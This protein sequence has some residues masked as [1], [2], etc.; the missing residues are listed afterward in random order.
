MPPGRSRRR[1]RCVGAHATLQYLKQAPSRPY[2]SGFAIIPHSHDPFKRRYEIGLGTTGAD[3]VK[4]A[5]RLSL[6]VVVSLLGFAFGWV[7]YWMGGLVTTRR[8]QFPDKENAGLT[9]GTFQLPFDEIA[10][11]APDGVELKG[12]WVPAPQ[13]R[14]TVVLL[15]GL[16]RSRLEMVRKAPFLHALGWNALLFDLR[17]H[18]QSGGERSTFG[19]L[20]RTDAAAATA[21]ARARCAGPVALWGVSLG[22]ATAVLAAA[23][24]PGIGGLVADSSYLSLRATVEHHVRLF[25]GFRWWTKLIP[26]WPLGPEVVFWIGRRGGFD[27]DGIDV[28]MAAARLGSRPSLWVCNSGDRRMPPEVAHTLQAAAG[29]Q[30]RLLTVEGNSHGGAYRD[31][32]ARYQAA[33]TELLRQVESGAGPR[34]A[35][36]GGPKGGVTWAAVTTK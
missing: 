26:A 28:R 23:D 36:A 11:A 35:Q 22:A 18:G 1:G 13:A 27:P 29:A 2:A 19:W 32:T 7:P 6:I 21:C 17:H 20:E 31:G 5:R 15:H 9:P 34:S 25:R 14:G 3:R 8:F 16:N 30:A 10:F 33:V 12:W 24:D 4:W